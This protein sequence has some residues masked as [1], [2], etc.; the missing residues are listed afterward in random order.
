MVTRRSFWLLWFCILITMVLCF[1]WLSWFCV[2]YHCRGVGVFFQSLWSCVHHG[3]YGFVFFIIAMVLVFLSIVM[4]FCS[5]Y[6]VSINAQFLAMANLLFINVTTSVNL[7]TSSMVLFIIQRSLWQGCSLTL[8]LFIIMTE[9]FNMMVY[10]GIIGKKLAK[11]VS[12]NF[13]KQKIYPINIWHQFH[14]QRWK[15]IFG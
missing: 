1:S 15:T 13:K 9:V 5:S 8:H 4:V 14:H 6:L 2:S 12:F 10:K 7:N 3:R 11:I